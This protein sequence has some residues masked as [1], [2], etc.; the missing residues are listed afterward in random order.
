MELNIELI[1]SIISSIIAFGASVAWWSLKK[2]STK[3]IAQYAEVIVAVLNAIDKDSDNG[4]GLSTK[5]IELIK[6][7][8]EDIK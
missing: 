1:L 3:K 5:E 4:M 2:L 8:I 7:E 6:K